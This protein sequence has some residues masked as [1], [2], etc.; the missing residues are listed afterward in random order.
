MRFALAAEGSRGDVQ[1]MVG[2]AAGL[3]ERGH[4]A[5]VCAPPDLR[6]LVEERGLEFRPLGTDIHRFLAE[7]AAALRRGAV[8]TTRLAK[9]LF[10]QI[11]EEQFEALPRAA[12]GADMIIGA[13]VQFAGASV[14][15]TMG[16]PYRAVAYCPALFRSADFPPPVFPNQSLP[17]WLNRLAWSGFLAIQNRMLRGDLNRHRAALGLGPVPDTYRYLVTERP[18]LV[19]D[20]ALAPV[21]DDAPVQVDQ[22]G[23]LLPKDE[24][25]LPPKLESFLQAGPPP[26]YLGFGSMMDSDPAGTTRLLL[27][28]VERAGCRAILARGWA[29][30]G[31]GPL[32]ESVFG[33]GPLPHANLFPRLAAVIHHGGAGTTTTAAR[34]GVPQIVIPHLL[35]QHY[36]G[37]RL[38]LLGVAPPPLP[39]LKLSAARL[40]ELISASLENELLADR[41]RELAERLCTGN[42]LERAVDS[43]LASSGSPTAS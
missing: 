35:D 8:V 2:L 31:D 14:A 3:V 28:A 30:L 32:P 10:Q 4:R 18:L 36:W 33:A 9:R 20:A 13:G 21:P 19:A 27:D 15:E 16:I 6:R 22:V 38:H 39:R 1:P 11:L 7:N 34:S 12:A 29:G 23:Y 43:I 5:V 25:P 41:A 26:V 37:H 17:R 24:T 42:P 40:A